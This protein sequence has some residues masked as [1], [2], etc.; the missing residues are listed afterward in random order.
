VTRARIEAC[1]EVLDLD[2][3]ASPFQAIAERSLSADMVFVGLPSPEVG[4]PS[5]TYLAHVK[6]LIERTKSL[7]NL[8]LVMAGDEMRKRGCFDRTLKT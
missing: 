2:P 8:A 7:P 1:C 3:T 5:A 6:E 4:E